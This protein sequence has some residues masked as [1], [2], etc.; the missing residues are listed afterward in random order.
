MARPE[1]SPGR[2][3]VGN[4]NTSDG[5][6]YVS[7][8]SNGAGSCPHHDR[9]RVLRQVQSSS[10]CQAACLRREA[11]HRRGSGSWEP[12]DE[13]FWL[14]LCM[15][16]RSS[17]SDRVRGGP[18][19]TTFAE[20]AEARFEFAEQTCSASVVIGPVLDGTGFPGSAAADLRPRHCCWRLPAELEGHFIL[21]RFGL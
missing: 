19:N 21:E 20:V 11:A 12:Q 7:L 6:R 18:A 15:A 5:P 14:Q 13:V 2:R 4:F 10:L 9:P 3:S 8:I 17:E 16:S 1:P